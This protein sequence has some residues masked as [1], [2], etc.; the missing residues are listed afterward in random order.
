MATLLDIYISFIKIGLSA[1]GAGTAAISM[2]YPELVAAHPH[3]LCQQELTDL[4]ALGSM[5]PGPFLGVT[6]ALAG[7]RIY[8]LAGA[9]VATIGL[10]TPSII[11]I[12]LIAWAVT[13]FAS[14]RPVHVLQRAIRPGALG[15]VIVATH[16]LAKSRLT[17]T[18]TIIMAVVSFA[19]FLWQGRKIHPALA[20]LAFGLLGLFI[21]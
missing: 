1:V 19:L 14:S 5:L 12:A 20:L 17:D 18:P 16:V 9:A 13:R 11:L 21:F 6:T 3:W 10:L 7:Y 15:L 2:M 4:I 8:G